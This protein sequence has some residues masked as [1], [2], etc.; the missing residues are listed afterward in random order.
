MIATLTILVSQAI[1]CYIR[2]ELFG[3]EFTA[4]G[5]RPKKT[6]RGKSKAVSPDILHSKGEYNC[7]MVHYNERQFFISI[8]S[9]V[10]M[11]Q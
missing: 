2:P 7:L 1:L 11:N 3:P 6:P 5:L 9:Y 10:I 4:E 8:E